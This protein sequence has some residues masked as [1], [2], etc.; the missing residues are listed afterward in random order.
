MALLSNPSLNIGWVKAQGGVHGNE[1]ANNLAKQATIKGEI[2]HLPVHKIHLK[3]L[4][5]RVSIN[6]WQQEWAIGDTGR[7]IYNIIPKVTTNPV[8]W[9]RE[10]I[11]L[12]TGYGPFP[13]Y[14]HMFNFHH[15]D[16]CACGEV[17]T[18]FHYAT[19]CHLTASYHFTKPNENLTSIWWR[20]I[21]TNKLSRL[22]IIN[23]VSFL[24]ENEDNK[25]SIR[26]K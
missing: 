21:L 2:H 6:K 3:N 17:G 14:L 26:P 20:N 12:A 13:S 19:T 23:L 8:P 18:P 4:L 25:T 5:H 9:T 22:K 1:T 16:L 7:T 15:S 10:S 24:I 11:L